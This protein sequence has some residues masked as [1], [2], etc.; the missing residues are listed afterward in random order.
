MKKQLFIMMMVV[1]LMVPAGAMAMKAMDH[2]KMKMDSSSGMAMGGDMVMLQGVEVDG[3]KAS[4]HLMD[5][6]KQMAEHGMSMTH[7]IMVGFMTGKGK[8]I[9]K[10]QVAVKVE[11][12]DGKVSKANKMMGMDGQFGTDVTLDQ[13]GTYT[14]MIGTKLA[15]GKQRMFHMSF[16]NS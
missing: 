6:K 1:L 4:A 5:T 15:D 2:S 13:K 8:N 7:H 10:G 9:E 12:P 14:F 16:D 11:S 3:V